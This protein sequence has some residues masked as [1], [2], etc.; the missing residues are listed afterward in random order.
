MNR[1]LRLVPMLVLLL[2]MTSCAQYV[3]HL[4]K[5]SEAKAGL[6]NLIKSLPQFKGLDV[7]KTVSL[8]FSN[9]EHGNGPPCYY[10]RGYIIVG[11]AL[12]GTEALEAYAQSLR[13]LGWTPK[14]TLY[15]TSNVL[16]Y[17]KNAR[18]E[19]YS[20]EPGVDIQDAADYAR[21]KQMYTSVIFIRLD[22]MLP[23][24]DEC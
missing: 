16:V 24:A 8:E 3:D 2:L 19:I 5:Q 20:G 6:D 21:L 7:V 13:L 17:E 14:G 18:L 23:S 4:Q 15:E 11:S 12:P 1:L 22:Y 10:A 9:I